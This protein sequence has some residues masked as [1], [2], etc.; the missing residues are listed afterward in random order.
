MPEVTARA[1]IGSSSPVMATPAASTLE[2]AVTE[3]SAPVAEAAKEEALSPRFAALARQQKQLR[4]QQ[5]QVKAQEASVQKQ[6]DE[7]KSKYET[8][9]I[10]KSRFS[11]DLYG[12]L[13]DA[14]INQEQLLQYLNNPANNDPGYRALQ[15][16]ITELESKV[17]E[18]MKM[19][20]AEKS[21]AYK[22]A[23]EQLRQETV[24]LV[25]T[26]TKFELIKN[27]GFSEEV[28]KTIEEEFKKTNRVM[29][30]AEAAEKI[31]N[32]LLEVILECAK[33][34]KIQQKLMP[35][36]EPVAEEI[37]VAPKKLG[38]QIEKKQ[39]PQQAQQPIKTLTN[40]A[41]STPSKPLSAREKRERAI[42]AF[43]GQL[44]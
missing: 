25:D 20:E 42:L 38:L 5:E 17:Q 7:M 22:N 33:L 26:D 21:Q 11:N 13:S 41:T 6:L 19:I 29:K 23:V 16:K 9:Y 4:L 14:G 32:D 24:A 10:P 39:A 8:D 28:V 3:T 31:E 37:P 34:P 35:V 27:L 43:K 30:P 18:P 12:A 15:A 2:A 36:V 40:A 44:N 1:P